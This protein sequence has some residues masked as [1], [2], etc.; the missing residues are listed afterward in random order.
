MNAAWSSSIGLAWGKERGVAAC[1]W[2]RRRRALSPPARALRRS[3]AYACAQ[4]SLEEELCRRPG[5]TSCAR[6]RVWLSPKE[7]SGV[8]EDATTGQGAAGCEGRGCWR[9]REASELRG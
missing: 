5:H 1:A 4:P 3:F 2:P 9:G 7:V 6:A 8:G